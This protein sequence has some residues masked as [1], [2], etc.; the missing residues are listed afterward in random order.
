VARDTEHF[1]ANHG[2]SILH[3]RSPYIDA[4]LALPLPQRYWELKLFPYIPTHKRTKLAD[5]EIV[6]AKPDPAPAAYKFES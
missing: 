4:I 1:L 5:P 6:L 2:T 3:R